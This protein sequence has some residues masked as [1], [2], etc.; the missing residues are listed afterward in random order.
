MADQPLRPIAEHL[1]RVMADLTPRDPDDIPIDQ[2]LGLAVAQTV[3][4][5]FP[6]PPFTNSAM[7]GYAVRVA[8]VGTLPVTLPVAADIPAGSASEAAL[9]PG[10]VYR[11]MTGA[12]IPTGADAVVPVEWTDGGVAQV[13]IQRAPKPIDS[14]LN[15]RPQGDDLPMGTPIAERGD[16]LDPAHLALLISAGVSTLLVYPQPRVAVVSTGDELYPVGT[17]LP[18]GGIYDS[19]GYLMA[20]L[21]NQAGGHVAHQIHV[22]DDATAAVQILREVAE[23]VDLI[24]TM[25]GVSAGA[26]EVIKDVFARIGHANFASVAMQP[27]KPQGVA[28]IGRTRVIALPGN[29]LSSLVSFHL[30]VRPAIRA[31]GGHGQVM[32]PRARL[33]TKTDLIART[34]RIRYLPGVADLIDQSVSTPKRHGSHRSSIAV[35]T[36]CLIEVQAANN[37]VPAGSQVDVILLA[38]S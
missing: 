12:A 31:L 35:G 16:S 3:T 32:P 30:F 2:V 17:P 9:E 4:S 7:D 8:D 5:E 37:T 19:N 36:N 24:V 15:I 22:T 1:V 25:G 13:V 21:V 20:A 14:G 23:D 28:N 38:G 10:T 34:D 6:L 33:T 11:I 27:G 29:P 18:P 26:Y